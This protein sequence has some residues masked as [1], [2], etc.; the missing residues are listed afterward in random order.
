MYNIEKQYPTDESSQVMYELFE[1]F[2]TT[3]TAH[4]STTTTTTTYGPTTTTTT[5]GTNTTTLSN[6]ETI[7]IHIAN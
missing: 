5:C 3:T 7:F 1:S 6:I 2:A 4:S